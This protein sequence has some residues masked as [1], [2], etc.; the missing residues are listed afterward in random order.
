MHSG[1]F[2]KHKVAYNNSAIK[3]A[4][5][6]RRRLA[7]GGAQGMPIWIVADGQGQYRLFDNSRFV[8][9]TSQA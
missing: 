2:N 9:L 7:S 1:K 6:F 8:V 3:A 5:S 4:R